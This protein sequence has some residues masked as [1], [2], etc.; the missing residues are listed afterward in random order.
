MVI[1]LNDPA[2]LLNLTDEQLEQ[3]Y[4]ETIQQEEDVK[5]QKLAIKVEFTERIKKT[6]QSQGKFGE[7]L[8][9][10]Y[11]KIYTNGVTMETAESFGATKTE[12]KIDGAVISK[13]YKAGNK[14]AGVEER[15]E[16]KVTK[17]K[18]EDE[19]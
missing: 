6:N 15:W 13:L 7:T 17:I 10:R 11:P 4:W 8:V 19:T 5:A 3:A 2:N 1:N 14:I 12:V 18:K 9:T 16:L